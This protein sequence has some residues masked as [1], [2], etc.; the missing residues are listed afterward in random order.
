M[1][2][3]FLFLFFWQRLTLDQVKFPFIVQL[4]FEVREIICKYLFR[5]L[6]FI[7]GITLKGSERIRRKAF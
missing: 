2:L 3:G 6:I 5:P 4:F 1:L 7:K